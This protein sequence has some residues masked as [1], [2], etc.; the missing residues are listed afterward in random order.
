MTPSPVPPLVLVGPVAPLGPGGHVSGIAKTQTQGPWRIGAQGLQGDA[1]ADRKHHGGAEKA[2]H[3]YAFD[4]Y[5]GWRTELGDM[6]LLD[7]PG[8]FGENLSTQGW[9]EEN[10][11]IGDVVRFGGALLQVSQGRQPCYKLSLRF[12]R[13]DMAKRLQESGRTGWYYRV[14]EPGVAKEGDR[15]ELVERRRP[16]WPLSRL[17]RLL[18]RDRDERAGLAAMAALDELAESWRTLAARRLDTGKVENWSARLYGRLRW[19]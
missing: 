8:A 12:G 13:R 7:A 10:V 4:H 5:A 1:Q 16:D 3:H 19:S 9:T 11:C 18:Y 14:L 17:T 6:S 15:L 2:L